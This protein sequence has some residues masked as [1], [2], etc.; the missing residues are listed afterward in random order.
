MKLILVPLMNSLFKLLYVVNSSAFDEQFIQNLVCT[1]LIDFQMLIDFSDRFW[2]TFG[3]GHCQ[4]K[5]QTC[6]IEI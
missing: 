3:V 6:E 4:K 5:D 2:R 1:Y